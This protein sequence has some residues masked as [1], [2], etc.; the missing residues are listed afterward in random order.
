MS[1]RLYADGSPSHLLH[2]SEDNTRVSIH[3][4]WPPQQRRREHRSEP[5]SLF[6]RDCCR[7]NR[8]MESRCRLGAIYAWSPFDDVQIQLENAL[9][10]KNEFRYRHKGKL[11]CLANKRTPRCEE[12]VLDS[13]LRNG[14]S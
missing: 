4:R 11:D 1:H 2:P 10:R 9:L 3:S 8:V 5:R 12:Q 7:R 14:G 6:T 13:L